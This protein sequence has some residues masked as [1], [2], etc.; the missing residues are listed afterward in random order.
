[1]IRYIAY[2]AT[3]RIVMV[4]FCRDE[5][6]ALQAEPGFE[7]MSHASAS[8]FTHKIVGGTPVEYTE[9]GKLRLAAPPGAGWS[10]DPV[11]ENWIDERP[12]EDVRAQLLVSLRM[13]RD[14]LL[15]GG[16]TWDGSIFD[17]DAAI[18]QPRLLG[19]FTTS[20]AGGIPPEGYPWRLKD[21]TWRVLSA[22]DAQ[23]VWGA[24]Q[25]RMAGLFGAFAVHEAA[26]VAET[27]VA[28][29]R[30]YDVEAGW[31]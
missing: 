6:L 23:A 31:P 27:D 17:S 19:L 7:V 25:T 5:D 30:A 3:G 9:A 18:S 22:A 11:S 10:W 16:F 20:I 24:F 15:E 2:D 28:V 26:V 8:P 21:N 1:M 14:A 29:L 4:G 12:I 13:Q